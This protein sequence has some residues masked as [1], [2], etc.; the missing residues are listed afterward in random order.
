M[1][2]RSRPFG[3]MRVH[4][5][6]YG[7]GPPLL[8]VHGLMTSSYS[9]RYTLPALGARFTCFAPDL[10]GNGRSE[11][12]L[13]ASYAPGA[14]AEW[15]GEV[16][17]ALEIRGCACVANS[18]GGYVAM[19]R[20]LADPGAFSR[21]LNAHSPG[22]PEWRLFALGAG[23]RIPGARALLRRAIARDPLRW[24]HRHVHYWDETLKS[25]EEAREYGAPLATDGGRRA[26]VKYLAETMSPWGARAFVRGLRERRAAGRAFPV[27][28]LFVYAE[29]DPMVPPRFGDVFAAL[30]PE[31]RLVRLR[32]ASHFAHVDAVERF[33]AVALDFLAGVE[34]A[35]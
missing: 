5:R 35:R 21:L 29:E 30:V 31:A 10:P 12:P 28:L 16:Q 7:A 18:M 1:P 32:E 2:L 19:Q 14:L 33:V 11:A 9:W 15:L 20:A 23:L 17:A 8:L 24:A 22:V 27:P 25:L 3:A 34:A 6:R 26:L 13:A 4:V